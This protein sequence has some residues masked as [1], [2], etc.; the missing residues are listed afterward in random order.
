MGREFGIL[1][2]AEKATAKWVLRTD[3]RPTMNKV[4]FVFQNSHAVHIQCSI[5]SITVY[6]NNREN[7]DPNLPDIWSS[8]TSLL[9]FNCSDNNLALRNNCDLQSVF[10]HQ[11]IVERVAYRT[12]STDQTLDSKSS[13]YLVYSAEYTAP[14]REFFHAA[15]QALMSMPPVKK[16]ISPN[17]YSYNMNSHRLNWEVYVWHRLEHPNIAQLFGTSYHMSG[18]PSMIMKW[19]DNGNAADFLRGPAGASADRRLLA[20][21]VARGLEYLHTQTSPIIHGDLKSVSAFCLDYMNQSTNY[22]EE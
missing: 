12:P 10:E 16:M 22:M 3:A 20:L 1:A 2:K 4:A 21:D 15:R 19:Y 11:E 9:F 6:R 5:T 8:K 7:W 17:R 14:K 18:R 13:K